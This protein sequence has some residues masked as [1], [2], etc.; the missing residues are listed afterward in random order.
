M[1]SDFKE[2]HL[3]I[4]SSDQKMTPQMFEAAASVYHR[5]I[6]VFSVSHK[7]AYFE[8]EYLP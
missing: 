5:P 8:K 1:L 2:K 7:M 6:I 4:K 3:C